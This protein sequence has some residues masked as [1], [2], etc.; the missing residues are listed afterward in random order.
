MQDGKNLIE[1]RKGW[2]RKSKEMKETDI[3]N[4]PNAGRVYDYIL[5]GHHN[6]EADRQAAEFMLSLVPST[7]KW[8]RKL[9][10]YLHEAVVQLSEDGFNHFLD[11]A[12]GLPTEE[13]I[14]S[15]VPAAKVIYID[16]DP[17]VVAFG[18]QILANASNAQYIEADIRNVREI[19][20]SPT[21]KKTFDPGQK[22]AIGFNAVSCFLD[23]DEIRSIAESLHDWAPPGSKLFAS[24]ETKAEDLMTPK[25]QQF[26]DMFDQLGSPYHFMTVKNAE[27]LMKP[28]TVDEN[29]FRPLAEILG[30]QDQI[31]EADREGVGLEFFGAIFVK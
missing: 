5:G 23:D 21:I 26:I 1:R 19:L 10:M 29:G 25:M 30:L 20:T 14:H 3:T 11:L 22:V 28:W 24:F 31:T 12:S 16:N 13:H 7:R 4:I 18:N 15:T 8:V 27:A 9:R 6:F 17:V 2:E